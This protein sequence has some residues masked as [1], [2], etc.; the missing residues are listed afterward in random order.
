MWKGAP[1]K[2]NNTHLAAK[3]H[4][5]NGNPS[6]FIAES[7]IFQVGVDPVEACP[8]LVVLPWLWNLQEEA[9]LVAGGH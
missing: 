7:F 9:L 1:V 4:M 3:L 5:Q 2:S 6:Y 8:Q